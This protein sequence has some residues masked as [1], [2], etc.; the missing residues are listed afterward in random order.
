[1]EPELI[2]EVSFNFILMIPLAFWCLRRNVLQL[3]Y[4]QRL[5]AISKKQ[6]IKRGIHSPG[7]TLN[8]LIVTLNTET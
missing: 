3:L 6:S 2:N 5:S 1:M 4:G 8:K 7:L